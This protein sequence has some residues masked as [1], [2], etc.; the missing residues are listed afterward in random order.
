MSKFK[1]GIPWTILSNYKKE[2]FSNTDF[3][4]NINKIIIIIVIK[5]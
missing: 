2:I 5:F 3:I 4:N 1:I